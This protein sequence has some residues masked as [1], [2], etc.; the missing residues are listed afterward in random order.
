[1]SNLINFLLSEVIIK[2]IEESNMDIWNGGLRNR[3]DIGII[4]DIYN[5]FEVII[6]AILL[7]IIII[8]LLINYDSNTNADNGSSDDVKEEQPRLR[9]VSNLRQ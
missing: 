9:F 4:D 6:M 3:N 7:I 1:M 2:T 5:E 8:V